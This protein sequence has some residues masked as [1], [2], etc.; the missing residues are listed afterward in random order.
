MV[1]NQDERNAMNDAT[2]QQIAQQQAYQNKAMPL[3]QQSL[4]QSSPNAMAQ[5]QQQGAQKVTNAQQQAALV[6]LALPSNVGSTNQ[7][8]Q[9][10][11]NTG[12][13]ARNALAQAS[14]AQAQGYSNIG[15]QQG[16]KDLLTNS[17]LGLINTE[18]ARSAQYFPQILEAA[19]QSEQGLSAAGGLLGS[20]GALLGVGSAVG[21]FGQSANATQQALQQANTMDI[22]NNAA[23]AYGNWGSWAPLAG[24]Y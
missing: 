21:A 24:G 9:N 23:N 19:G 14:D 7:S 3:F 17:Q 13:A 20:L 10:V 16:I 1:A 2:A 12:Q 11:S 5:Q 15:L 4:A 6:P 22:L 8:L 18:A